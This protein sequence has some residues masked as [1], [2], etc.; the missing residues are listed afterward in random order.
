MVWVGRVAESVKALEVCQSAPPFD[1]Y[2][3]NQ[4]VMPLA[5]MSPTLLAAPTNGGTAVSLAYNNHINA[6]IGQV[7]L[8]S[9]LLYG[10][11]IDND[12]TINT[13]IRH[14]PF[15]T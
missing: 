14:F 6:L 15:I 8:V 2:D 13:R 9:W 10:T 7:Q 3:V 12:F 1:M 4:N 5:P 11:V